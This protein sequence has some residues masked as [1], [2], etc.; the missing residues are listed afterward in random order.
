[1]WRSYD[2]HRM[3]TAGALIGLAVDGVEIE[4]I[5]AT[6]KTL[7]QFPALWRELVHGDAG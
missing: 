1:V 2:D 7:P 4:N 5:Q 6:A 3:S